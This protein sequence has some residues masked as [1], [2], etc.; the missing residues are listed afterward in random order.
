MFTW[1]RCSTTLINCIVTGN[2]AVH[3][4]GGLYFGQDSSATVTDCTI[5]ENSAL[6]GGGGIICYGK[7][8]ATL[9]GCIIDRNS[10]MWGGGVM[11]ERDSFATVTDCIISR[12]SA[13]WG[14]GLQSCVNSSITLANC[15]VWGN[16]ADQSGGGV[17]CFDG[18]SVIITNSILSA[19][20]APKGHEISLRRAASTSTVSYSNVA[21]G[22]TEATS[23]GGTLNWGEGNMN[24]DPLFADPNGGDLHLKS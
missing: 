23:E 3:A 22:P 18:F 2:S 14:G 6:H 16:S 20:T 4:G 11:S 17:E 7:S 9:I 10:A 1:D 12:N 8:L 13:T 15:T 24:D 21:A 5:E 19:N